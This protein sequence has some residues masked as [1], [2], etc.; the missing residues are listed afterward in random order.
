MTAGRVFS[1]GGTASANNRTEAQAI[2]KAGAD[3][4]ASAN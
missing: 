1:A 4:M 3:F 2:R